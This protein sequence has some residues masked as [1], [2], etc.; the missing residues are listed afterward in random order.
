MYDNL[1][2]WVNIYPCFAYPGTPLYD[3]YVSEGRIEVPK[4]W[5]TYG[6]YSYECVPLPSKHLSSAEV[7]R[8]RDSI[9]EG[10]YKEPEILS[11]LERKFGPA[12]RK[13]VEDMVKIPL[14]RRIL[15]EDAGAPRPGEGPR[16]NSDPA[17]YRGELFV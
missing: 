5:D 1:F 4:K 14:R 3:R 16:L 6:L 8:L 2:E 13:H 15:E 17:W 7:L 11:M 10:Y 12:T 9:F